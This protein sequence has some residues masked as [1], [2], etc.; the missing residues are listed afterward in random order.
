MT[1]KELLKNAGINYISKSFQ[2]EDGV[3]GLGL[4][5]FETVHNQLTVYLSQ[6]PLHAMLN[7]G[8]VSGTS[9]F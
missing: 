5:P 8:I 2:T 9:R 6:C 3:K 1:L 7:V 4:N